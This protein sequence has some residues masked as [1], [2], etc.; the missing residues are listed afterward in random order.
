M[1]VIGAFTSVSGTLANIS[2]T[3]VS[4]DQHTTFLDD[5]F[6]FLAIDPLIPVPVAAVP[7]PPAMST[8]SISTDVAFTYPGGTRAGGRRG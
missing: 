2:S 4:V 5:Y 3:F 1:L 8:R 7:L 6:S